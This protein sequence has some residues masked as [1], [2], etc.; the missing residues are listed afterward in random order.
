[1]ESIIHQA[2]S[3]SSP[4]N[5]GRSVSDKNDVVSAPSEFNGARWN[6]IVHYHAAAPNSKHKWTDTEQSSHHNTQTPDF[7]YHYSFSNSFHYKPILWC[8]KVL[9]WALLTKWTLVKFIQF[10]AKIIVLQLLCPF[11]CK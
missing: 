7:I 3:S 5:H 1:M 9:Y 6:M 4:L 11:S 2:K 10:I 8:G